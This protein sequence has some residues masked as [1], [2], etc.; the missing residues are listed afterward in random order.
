MVQSSTKLKLFIGN[1]AYSSW[2][3]RGWLA[4]KLS[5]LAFEEIVVPLYDE[6]WDMRRQGDA[7]T[8]GGSKVP[9]LWEGDIVIWDSL[10]IIEWLADRTGRNR[11]WPEADHPRAL[12]RSMAAEMHSGFMALRQEC[13]MNLRHRLSTPRL[14][15]K[16]QADI[17]RIQ[18]LWTD[19]RQR[20]GTNGPYLFGQFG[21][22]DIMFAPVVTRFITYNIPV[23]AIVADYMRAVVAHPFM[24]EWLTDAAKESWIIE[25]FEPSTKAS[26]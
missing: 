24:A 13:V 15:A 11:F 18:H 20:F 26:A 2:S 8:P 19:A 22:A 12:A 16:A 9:I 7:F 17:D 14:S 23:S 10:A 3:L 6:E 5:E 25:R 4:V 21:A 1:K